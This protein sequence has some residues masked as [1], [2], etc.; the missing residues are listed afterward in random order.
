MTRLLVPADPDGIFLRRE[1]LALGYTDRDLLRALRARVLHRIRHGAYTDQE[2]WAP[3]DDLGQ[4]S[5]TAY[6]VVRQSRTK[7][8]LSHVTAAIQHGAPVWDLPLADVHVTRR[9]RRAGRHEAGV[10]QHRSVLLPE[11]IQVGARRV[12]S[13]T[14]TALDLT[15]I[16]DIEHCLPVFD[17][18][19]H[20]ELTSKAELRAGARRMDRTP[21]TLATD[22]VIALADGRRESVGE[23]RTFHMI[24]GSGTPLPEPQYEIY[25]ERGALVAVVDFAWRDQKVFL[26]F[27]GKEKYLKFRREGESIVDAV[28][29]EKRREERI[30]RLTGWRCIRIVWADLYRPAA[31]IARIQSV[32]AGGPVHY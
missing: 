13:P 1:A 20:E 7:V 25:D 6:A 15:T 2:T 30:C 11:D 27:D 10:A 3:L 4:H 18:L 29:R 14:R 31:T 16:F 5:L 23:S 19:L 28:L 8:V 17:H 22:L 24:W 32:L 12:T 21:G 9:D 26:E